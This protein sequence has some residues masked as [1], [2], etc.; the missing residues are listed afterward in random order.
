MLGYAQ[1]RKRAAAR[2]QVRLAGELAGPMRNDD[3]LHARRR[4]QYLKAAADD[5]EKWRCLADLD[6]HL[7]LRRLSAQTLC[8]DPMDLRFGE[9]RKQPF[10][11][12]GC[13]GS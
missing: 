8:R 5:D 13:R 2:D 4:T 3:R 10:R 9:R 6:Q 11:M 7:T 1:A 12:R